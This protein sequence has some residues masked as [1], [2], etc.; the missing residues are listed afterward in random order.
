[1]LCATAAAL[2]AC[3]GGCGGSDDSAGSE[4]AAPITAEPPAET[5][6]APGGT[7]RIAVPAPGVWL[8]F[9]LGRCC[10]GRTLYATNGRSIDEEGSILR[11]DLAA[12]N[13]TVSA[14]GLTWTFTL[15]P[16]LH[17]GPPFEDTEIT[18]PDIVR[19]IERSI[20]PE[21]GDYYGTLYEVIEGARAFVEGRADTIS[22]LE[23]PDAHTLVVHLTSPAGDLPY[24]FS[25]PTTSPIPPGAEIGHEADYYVW[26]VATGPYM[27]EGAGEVDY[28]LPPADQR[29]ASGSGAHEIVLVRN[30]AWDRASDQLRA[31]YPERIEIALGMSPAEA[32]HAVDQGATDL[33]I[34]IDTIAPPEQ[35]RRYESDPELRD[36][37]FV[38]PNDGI[39]FLTLNVL[40]PPLDDVHV[41]R[42]VN[43]AIDKRALRELAGGSFAGRTA[44]HVAPDSLLD[45]LLLG[46]DPYAT[47]DAGGDLTSARAEMARSR[48]D[49]DRDGRCDRAACRKVR[50]LARA[51]TFG[52]DLVEV[53]RRSLEPLGLELD[54][55][56][57][58]DCCSGEP[59]S[60]YGQL[61]DP[62]NRIALAL[63]SGYGKDFTAASTFFA[64]QV[65]SN[66][67]GNFSRVGVG[68][69]TATSVDAKIDECSATTGLRQA[70]CWAELDQELMEQ[71]VPVVP[72]LASSA[73]RVVSARVRN[74]TVDAWTTLPAFDRIALAE[75]TR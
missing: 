54:V 1:M 66:S 22:G 47:P 74:Y 17:Y 30:P 15:K 20:S 46:Y 52:P 16:G 49:S 32:A 6:P 55:T 65:R 18:A 60:F 42:A 62:D 27:Y 53:V 63:G 35:L 21:A 24:R 36:R 68:A 73:A 4:A 72:W 25:L 51:D 7:L 40:V 14:D 44:T 59:E 75:G 67:G 50:A 69:A 48:Y 9:E 39:R 12:G 71:V 43:L 33:A 64:E 61:F 57:V 5:E 31:A 19:A 37:L 38:T 56:I 70:T 10:L 8:D 3:A 29:P 2:A 58:D 11:P 28:K 45:N 41:R 26:F 34:D 13:P 23:T